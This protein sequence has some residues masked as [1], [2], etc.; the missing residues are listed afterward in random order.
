MTDREL[1]EAAT[2]QGDKYSPNLRQWVMSWNRRMCKTVVGPV[3]NVYRHHDG[4]LWVGYLDDFDGS[5]IGAR[6]M[7]ILCEGRKAKTFCNIGVRNPELVADFWSQY[8]ADGR[9]AI[10]REHKQW[11]I[12]DDT[13]WKIDGDT[14]QCVWCGKATQ[15]LKRW[16]EEV[17]REKWEAAAA[18]TPSMESKE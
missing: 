5:L 8:A 7:S 2:R 6:M 1:L 14:R 11:F 9:C 16:T 12:G 10:D 18:L 4:S 3:P 13:R 17:Q 15:R